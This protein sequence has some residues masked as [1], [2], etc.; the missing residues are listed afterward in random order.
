MEAHTGPT[1]TSLMELF[2][3]AIELDP[4]FAMAYAQLGVV[5]FFNYGQTERGVENLRKAYQ[6]RERISEREK[7]YISSLLRRFGFRRLGG[8]AKRLRVVDAALPA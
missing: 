6:L 1:A 5:L 7:F 4:N 3:R 8:G 2:Q